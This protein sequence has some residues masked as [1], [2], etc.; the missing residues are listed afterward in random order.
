MSLAKSATLVSPV[1]ERSASQGRHSTMLLV[2]WALALACTYMVLFS[3]R[4]HG[5]AG[6]GSSVVLAFLI[7]NFVIGRL[8]TTAVQSRS[9]MV[10]IGLLDAVL[11][12]ASLQASGQLSVELVL[13][14][15]GIVIL[16]VAGL[17][18]PTIAIASLGMMSVYMLI[19]AWTGDE[20]PW[21]TGTLL[22]LP[23]LFTAAVVYA[24]FVEQGSATSAADG[25]K[26]KEDLTA[27][28]QAIER[29]RLA[30][31]S[32]QPAAAASALAEIE[33]CARALDRKLAAA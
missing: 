21:H 1:G 28:L 18:L 26:A 7:M 32:E 17:R 25:A 30:L 24:W 8:D 20:S 23:F 12:V 3:E 10:T 31:D 4:S 6:W 19:V 16:A 29:C 5:I 15:L 27:Q 13:L 14:C 2:Q 33:Q 9:A 22:R 11:I